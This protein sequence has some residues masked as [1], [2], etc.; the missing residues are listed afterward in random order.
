[1]TTL[2]VT[3][4]DSTADTL[5]ET[6]LGGNVVPWRDALHEGPLAFDAEESRRIR[7]AFLSACGWGNEETIAPELER[8]DRE[9]A[10]AAHVALWFEH[11]LYDQLQLLQV[12]SQVDDEQEVEL[13]ETT[14]YL[15]AFDAP[16]LE[17]LWEKRRRVAPETR[18]L[19]ADAWR[20][21]CA[22]DVAIV[23]QHDTHAL[24]NLRRA[25]QRFQEERQPLSRTKRQ[26]LTA[27]A[28]G[29]TTPLEAFHASQAQEEAVFLGDTWCFL[30]LFELSR[31]GLVSPLP[32]PPPR[33]DH[34]A[35]VTARVELTDAGREVLSRE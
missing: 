6:S 34:D 22:G 25:L 3:N 20:S 33:G 8:R 30:K 13:I 7:A 15:G 10:D 35:F 32:L 5:R 31:D 18:S 2:H 12:L 16:A 4:G 24:P 29:A 27:I 11:D 21:I 1:M 9:L 28:D 19:A 17:A 23:L 26:L 14:R